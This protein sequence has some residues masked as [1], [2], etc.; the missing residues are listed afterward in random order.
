MTGDRRT[1]WVTLTDQLIEDGKIEPGN[2]PWLSPSFP[3][4]KKKPGAYILVVDF[5]RLNEATI[6]DSHPLSRIGDILQRQ[7]QFQIWSVLD[8]KDG[9]HE[10][11]L[12]R[13]TGT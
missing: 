11:L 9:Y 8:M 2:G 7:G 1:A 12:K 10:V 4:P 13:N 3:V 5:R 6:E